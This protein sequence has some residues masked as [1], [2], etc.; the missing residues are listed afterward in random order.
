L[1]RASSNAGSAVTAARSE[2]I[3]PGREALDALVALSA[4]GRAF[5]QALSPADRSTPF[6]HPEY[7][8]LTVDWLMSQMAGHHRHHLT[9]LEQI[10]KL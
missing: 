5:F 7:G 10:A 6:T 1:K 8:A 2:S 9:Q 4:M 3:A